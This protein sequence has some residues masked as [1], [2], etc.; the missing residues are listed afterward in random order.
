MKELDCCVVRDLLPLYAERLTAPETGEQIDGH[1]A[2]CEDCRAY[3]TACM[4]ELSVPIEKPTAQDKRIIWGMRFQLLWYLFWPLL[5]A[6]S[7]LF[8]IPGIVRF[9]V[10]MAVVIWMVTMSHNTMYIYDL[11]DTKK[12]FYQ[13]EE[14]N[15]GSGKGS[16]LTQGILW[17]LPLL[18][19]LLLELARWLANR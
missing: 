19:P 2:R 1:L 13:R 14:K 7:L 17:L 18:L 9:M 4:K 3:C 6:G 5:Y 15:I 16:F 10:I 11:D 12:A 8:G